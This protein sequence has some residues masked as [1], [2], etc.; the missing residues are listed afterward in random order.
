[1]SVKNLEKKNALRN[2]LQFSD[3]SVN[4]KPKIF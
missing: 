3:D 2:G 4:S 1:M